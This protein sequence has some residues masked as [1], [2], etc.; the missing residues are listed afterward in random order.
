MA[1]TWTASIYSGL[2]E[3]EEVE[4]VAR[5]FDILRSA[6]GQPITGWLSPG[7]SQSFATPDILAGTAL[8][9]A[10]DWA[11]D[12]LPYPMRTTSDPYMRCRTRLKPM[13]AP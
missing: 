1:S 11:N 5:T 9:Y 13:T 4:L 12:D 6:S 10:C 8:T 2:P 3:E 7:R